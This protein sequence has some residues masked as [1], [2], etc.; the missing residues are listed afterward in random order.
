MT[1][2]SCGAT[3]AEKAI[4]CYR[5]GAPTAEPAANRPSPAGAGVGRLRWLVSAGMAV[6]LGAVALALPEEAA[7]NRPAEAGF[8]A[9]TI[10]A[11][12]HWFRQRKK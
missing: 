8:A 7:A 6:V 11:A 9:A 2:R 1:C 4:V 3:I 5:C 10:L 12:W